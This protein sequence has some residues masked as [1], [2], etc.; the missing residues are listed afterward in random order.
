MNFFPISRLSARVVTA[1]LGWYGLAH[2]ARAVATA[3][4]YANAANT[5]RLQVENVTNRND[6]VS[7]GGYPGSGYLVLGK[8]RTVKL[9]ATWEF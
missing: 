5:L 2:G 4:R 9:N 3:S 7:V 1:W 6:W 8:P